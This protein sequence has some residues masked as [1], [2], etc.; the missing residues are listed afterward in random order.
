MKR[1]EKRMRLEMEG[2]KMTIVMM[3]R[4]G[5][6]KMRMGVTKMMMM[7]TMTTGPCWCLLMFP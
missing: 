6:M 5:V 3:L 7:K 2:T 4:T 1:M